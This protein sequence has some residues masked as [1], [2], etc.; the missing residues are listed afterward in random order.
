M[1]E[2]PASLLERLRRCPDPASWQR[3][4]AIYTPLLRHW[5]RRHALQPADADDLVQEV[6]AAA[7]A[8]LPRFQYDREK[9]SFRSW[10]RVLTVNRLRHFWRAQQSR[11][12]ATGDSDFRKRV[13]DQLADPH[14]DLSRLWDAEHDRHVAHQLLAQ[15]E[16]EFEPTTWRAFRRTVLDGLQAAEAAAELGM[17]VNAVFIAKSRVMRRLRQEMR[18]LTD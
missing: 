3:L 8:E 11:P 6:L 13:L 5:L 4:V 14:S 9:G 15:L 1:S 17:S 10:L 16:P 18:G 2:T 12:T 7:A